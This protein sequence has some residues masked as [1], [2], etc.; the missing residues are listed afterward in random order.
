MSATSNERL[1]RFLLLALSWLLWLVTSAVGFVE[2]YLFRQIVVEI[3]MNFST[4]RAPINAIGWGVLLITSMI[5]LGYAIG[6]FEYLRARKGRP[7]NWSPF[8]WAASIELLI[9]I[10]YFAV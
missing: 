10:L 4:Q 7:M 3:Y 9:L 8:A 6:M 5:W 2:I 1:K